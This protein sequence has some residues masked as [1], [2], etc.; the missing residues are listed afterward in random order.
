MLQIFCITMEY[1]ENSKLVFNFDFS[2]LNHL[3]LCSIVLR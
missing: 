2:L 1:S 3:A